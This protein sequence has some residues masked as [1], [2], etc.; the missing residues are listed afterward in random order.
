MEKK[1][2]KGKG[3]DEGLGQRKK[4]KKQ[5]SII[6][7]TARGLTSLHTK[8]YQFQA[9]LELQGQEHRL[10]MVVESERRALAVADQPTA[11]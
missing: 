1:G 9:H 11:M 4:G 6:Q 10:H 3:K 8:V 2:K 7:I 5:A